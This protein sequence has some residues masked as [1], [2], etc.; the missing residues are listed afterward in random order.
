MAI[1]STPV[2][3]GK[4]LIILDE[5][6]EVPA[7]LTSLKYFAED[8]PGYHIVAAGSLLGICIHEG[9]GFPVGKVERLNMYS[10]SFYEFLT[11]LGKKSCL[12]WF[13]QDDGMRYHRF[14]LH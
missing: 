11:A 14:R 4:T 3:E 7:A 12:I 9:S 8:N 5:I 10:M 13:I 6:Q 2:V 1:T